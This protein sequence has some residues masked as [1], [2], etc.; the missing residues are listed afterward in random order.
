MNYRQWMIEDLKNLDKCR[1]AIKQMERELEEN[2][3]ER[4]AIKATNYDKIPGSTGENTQEEK[5]LTVIAKRAELEAN[6][7]ATQLHVANMENL[8]NQLSDEERRIIQ[9]MCIKHE[10]GGQDRLSEEFGYEKTQIYKMRNDALMHLAQ[11]R[12][13][14]GYQT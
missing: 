9:V 3:A 13:G 7:V 11:L 14:K 4:T 12:W 10:K 1:F 6:L 8:L 5:I 2:N